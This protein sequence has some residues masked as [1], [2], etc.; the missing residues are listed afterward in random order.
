MLSGIHQVM[1]QRGSFQSSA[2]RATGTEVIQIID[3]S[4]CSLATISSI[5]IGNMLKGLEHPH[6]HLIASCVN[7]VR[8][9]F[10][11]LVSA[12]KLLIDPR[13]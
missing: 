4:Y 6:R 2:R 3:W 11:V 8:D 10:S 5:Y 13:G 7:K 12:E 9:D 1:L